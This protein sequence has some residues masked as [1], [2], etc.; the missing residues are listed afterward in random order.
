[1]KK[2]LTAALGALLLTGCGQTTGNTVK[3]S[4]EALMHHRY[5]LESVDGKPFSSQQP[6]NKRAQTLSF[7][8]NLHISGKMCNSF[9][10]QGVLNDNVLKVS[11]IAMTRMFC[12]NSQLNQLD[13]TIGKMLMG[14][15]NITLENDKLILKANGNTLVY[16]RQDLVQ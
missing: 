9:S 1:M 12:T 15:A 3:V 2:I 10:G 11:Q 6:I 14:G 8:E 13:Q 5:V 4:P 7:G 16:Q